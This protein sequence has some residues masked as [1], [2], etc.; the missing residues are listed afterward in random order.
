MNYDDD[1]PAQVMD[2]ETAKLHAQ[3]LDDLADRQTWESRQRVFYELRHNGLRRKRKPFMNAADLH[4]PLCDDIVEKW[5]PFYVGQLFAGEHI[6]QFTALVQQRPELTRDTVYWFD[7]KVKEESNFMVELVDSIDHMLGSQRALL[8]QRWD[9]EKRQVVYE[10]LD[11]VMVIV[12]KGTKELQETDRATLVFQYSKA[13]YKRQKHF[14]QDEDFLKLIC[15]ADAE[16][17]E[18]DEAKYTREGITH[19]THKDMIVVWETWEKKNDVWTFTTYS[20]RRPQE[21]IRPRTA[22]P[23]KHKYLP[24]F[25]IPREIRK[26]FYAPRGET[27]KNAAF[28]RYA[29]KVW[30]E[31]ADAMTYYN[32]PMFSPKSGADTS[33]I[34][35]IRLS[36]GKVAPKEIERIQM[37]QP[38]ISY[39]QELIN[40][41][42]MSEQHSQLPDLG[43]ASASG[44]G[45]KPK[46][47][48]E[49][50]QIAQVT[51]MSTNLRIWT[52]RLYLAPILQAHYELLLQYDSQSLT[53]YYAAEVGAL[54]QEALH[55]NYLVK[56][57]GNPESWNKALRMA[58]RDRRWEKFKGDP[59][60]NQIELRKADLEEDDPR[61]VR[62]LVLDPNEKVLTEQ[63]QEAMEVPTLLEG[64]PIRPKPNEDHLV[65]AEIIAGKMEAM[66]MSNEPGTPRQTQSLMRH[67]QAHVQAAMEQDPKRA[68]EYVKLK[69]KQWGEMRGEPA[70]E[71]ER[72]EA[73]G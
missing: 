56:V 73:R 27:E 28:E 25:E 39:D 47:A 18:N 69:Q 11:P 45:G 12:P 8:K 23:Y 32:N 10:S 43:L 9:S 30:N 3:V 60:I 6:A 65:R 57:D 42:H 55:E 7:Y 14:K 22:V 2:S 21:A 31:K 1:S 49:T 71:G 40:V 29:C 64:F 51:G 26:G 46:T 50:A 67:W 59:F 38:P 54:P 17:S 36:P 53:Y 63:E 37:G 24:I 4:L 66:A 5:K 15:G 41:R 68:K 20:P 33:G 72:L 35:N 70:Q 61:L 34:Q 62:R 19:G 13:E 48:T 52:F 58:N 16:H 44:A